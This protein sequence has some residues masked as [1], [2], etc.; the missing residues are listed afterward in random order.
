MGQNDLVTCNEC[1]KQFSTAYLSDH[2]R[3]EHPPKESNTAEPGG[4]ET[5]Q[6]KGHKSIKEQIDEQCNFVKCS[7]CQEK[8][9]SVGLHKHMRDK[10]KGGNGNMAAPGG[11]ENKPNS[12]NGGVS[13]ERSKAGK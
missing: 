9:S 6:D 11:K 8:Y 12:G 5:K 7:I 10:H 4:K 3:I 1:Y 2:K 13:G